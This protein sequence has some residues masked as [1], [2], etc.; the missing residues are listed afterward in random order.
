MIH[1]R[2]CR[3]KQASFLLFKGSRRAASTVDYLLQTPT[4]F[5]GTVLT[6]HLMTLPS[7][8]AQ[9]V[10]STLTECQKVLMTKVS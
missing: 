6:P 8:K 2:Y 5:R 1:L 10:A 4:H 3:L 7:A 9:A